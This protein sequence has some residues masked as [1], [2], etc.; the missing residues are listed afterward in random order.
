[1]AVYTAADLKAGTDANVFLTIFGNRPDGVAVMTDKIK[2]DNEK[3]NFERA[4]VDF[5][6]IETIKLGKPYK[7]II[8]HDNTGRNSAWN[9]DRVSFCKW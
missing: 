7:I 3:N 1:M 2:L 6:R 4:E 5:F 9:L 8:S